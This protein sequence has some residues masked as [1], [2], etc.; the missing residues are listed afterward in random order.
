[1][2]RT[3][4]NR[5]GLVVVAVLSV[6]VALASARYALP[7][8]PGVPPSVAENLFFRPWLAAHA[9][10]DRRFA[11]HRA[12]MV[13][14]F[15]LTFGA[16]TLRLYLPIGPLLGFEFEPSYVVISFL[17][18]VPNLAVAELILRRRGR[19]TATLAAT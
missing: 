6:L 5:T 15:A 14:S 4:T 9:V 19:K 1:M 11:D 7:D 16:V 2:I 13:R 8:A 3:L 18:W 10:L 17:S 12:W